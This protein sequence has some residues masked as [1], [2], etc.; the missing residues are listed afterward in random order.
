MPFGLC[1][2]PSVFQRY[3]NAILANISPENLMIY[4]NDILIATHSE[5]HNRRITLAVSKCLSSF[6]LKGK[7]QK[8]EFLTKET[9][10]LGWRISKSTFAVNHTHINN[11]QNFAEPT[12]I[13][14]L[15]SFLGICNYLRN[16]IPGYAHA[17]NYLN[18]LVKKKR[19]LLDEKASQK[20][21][22][23]KGMLKYTKNLK[24]PDYKID[25]KICTDASDKAIGGFLFKN[26]NNTENTD[27][28]HIVSYF[29][30]NL[31]ES[32][33]SYSTIE[34]ELLSLIFLLDK[35]CH[36]LHSSGRRIHPYLD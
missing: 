26:D 36:I 12:T 35:C 18:R 15:Q 28:V 32:E 23:I 6:N 7:S 21:N 13:K 9:I 30:R 11:I 10:F 5:A 1:H 24:S 16:F 14:K 4:L 17:T 33:K 3:I 8:C 2:A 20:F 22:T 31:L 29:S 25:L 27:T 19:L 34:Q